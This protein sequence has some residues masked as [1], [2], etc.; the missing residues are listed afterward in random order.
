MAL[1]MPFRD[2]IGTPL[3][4]G[5]TKVLLLGAGELGKEIA[6]EAQRLGV[7]TVTVDRYDNPPAAQ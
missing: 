7:E 6:I 3:Y 2:S 1:L 4:E 5:C